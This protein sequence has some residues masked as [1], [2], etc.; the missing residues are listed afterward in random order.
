[1]DEERTKP[2]VACTGATRSRVSPQARLIVTHTGFNENASEFRETW[3]AFW[4]D[5]LGWLLSK[6]RGDTSQV[7]L[8]WGAE[9]VGDLQQRWHL[10]KFTTTL[11]LLCDLSQLNLRQYTTL[12]NPYP[13]EL[14]ELRLIV[15]DPQSTDF[16]NAQ[17]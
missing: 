1:M 11:S 13:C 14:Y 12:E 6:R 7:Y 10:D 8:R 9:P 4:E 2:S 16:P 17:V 5:G 3:V 15:K